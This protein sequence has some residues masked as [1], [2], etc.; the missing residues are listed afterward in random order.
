MQT[1]CQSLYFCQFDNAA[2]A[3]VFFAQVSSLLWSEEHKEIISGHGFAKHE[4]IIWKY[5]SM[6]RVADLTG[7]RCSLYLFAFF[8][9]G[10]CNSATRW[11]ALYVGVVRHTYNDAVRQPCFGVWCML[12]KCGR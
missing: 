1:C 8:A 5:P 4:L 3:T 9:S 10:W 6:N 12:L 11:C 7:K 2:L